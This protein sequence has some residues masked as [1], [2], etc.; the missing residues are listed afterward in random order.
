MSAPTDVSVII[1]TRARPQRL[2][3]C[4]DGLAR[5]TLA[6]P[7]AGA[8][9]LEVVVATDGPCPQTSAL[10][11]EHARWPF[12][13][14]PIECEKLGVAHAKNRALE[15]S[16]GSLALFLN[17]DVIPTP[18][19]VR[20]H[21]DA[22]HAALQDGR[23]SHGV[24]VVG[25]SPWMV[26]PTDTVLMAMLRETSMVF[27]YDQMLTPEGRPTRPW[28]HDWGFRHAW[29]LNYSAPMDALKRVS[30]F[31]PALAN[32]CFEDIELAHRLA[33]ALA[34]PVLFRPDAL[35]PH[36]HPYTAEG[37]LDREFRLGY[38]A[39]GFAQAAP[40]CARDVFGRDL[41]SD[42]EIERSKA[43][44]NEERGEAEAARAAFVGLSALPHHI[45]AGAT[46]RAAIDCAL[47]AQGL[48]KRC[49]FARGLVAASENI[50]IQGVF[51]TSNAPPAEPDA[52][53]GAPAQRSA[54]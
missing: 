49:A 37:Y 28:D 11:A 47:V 27:F 36:D 6:H 23:W 45:V 30:G 19:L 20:A 9:T 38:S 40:E 16:T 41:T 18:G 32:C 52:W 54:A 5:Q 43:L 1:P 31:R 4:L 33:G 12:T 34:M 26:R 24:S 25:H 13:I 14:K 10:L 3:A 50:E 15:A 29:T 35:A 39:S 42:D 8:I 53:A 51:S 7:E 2:R 22:H 44:A 21:V 48:A 46:G 17:D